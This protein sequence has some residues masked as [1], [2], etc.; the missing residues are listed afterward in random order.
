MT[1]GGSRN[2]SGPGV[3]LGSA[4]SDARGIR[5]D[6][7]PS[8]G[9]AGDP[10]IAWPLGDPA[11]YIEVIVNGKPS[12]ELDDGATADRAEAERELWAE[13]WTYP[14]AFVWELER[15]RWN[16]V[17][18]WVRTFLVCTGPEAKAADKSSLHRFGDQLGLTPAGLRENG[19]AIVRSELDLKRAEREPNL[20]AVENEGESARPVR[21]LRG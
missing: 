11:V 6:E 15:W 1:R 3:D 8:E 14:Q 17:A 18:L 16:I 7:L 4:R 21:R 10:P 19:W 20:A 5:Y 12:R 9:R 2:R 13:V